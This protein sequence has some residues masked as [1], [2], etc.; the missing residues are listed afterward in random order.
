[1]AGSAANAR[2]VGDRSR[3]GSAP[4]H[5]SVVKRPPERRGVLA[6]GRIVKLL[7]GQGHGYIRLT[8]GRDIFF[9]RADLSEGVAFNALAV[10]D[11]V[12][13]ELVDDAVS[14]PRAIRVERRRG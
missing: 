2:P 7:I 1:V 11:P 10:G 13:F 3:A 4:P 12:T 14:G 9:H 5:Q 8:G 6:A